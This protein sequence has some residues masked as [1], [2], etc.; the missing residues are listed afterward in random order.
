MNYDLDIIDSEHREAYD[1]CTSLLQ[2]FMDRQ[3]YIHELQ[4][5]RVF[6]YEAEKRTNAMIIKLLQWVRYHLMG[7][8]D[9]S[10]WNKCHLNQWFF[11][12][13]SIC[14][15][16][17]FACEKL[18]I[19]DKLQR[20]KYYEIV[21]MIFL[22]ILPEHETSIFAMKDHIEQSITLEKEVERMRL[23]YD[24]KIQKRFI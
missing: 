1:N 16:S 12:Y 17:D 24:E 23:Q 15:E 22:K 10:I 7:N 14:V 18:E 9:A 8:D 13:D 19:I 20:Y 3:H 2:E 4:K 5:R 21:E 6:G 11:K